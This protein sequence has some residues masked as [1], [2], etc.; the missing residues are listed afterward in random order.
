MRLTEQENA[1]D[2]VPLISTKL[3]MKSFII[4]KMVGSRREKLSGFPAGCKSISKRLENSVSACRGPQIECHRP[5]PLGS[6]LFNTV[7]NG[8][9]VDLR[10]MCIRIF[11]DT[12]GK[13]Y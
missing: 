5:L 12:G 13:G 9:Q 4:Y 11:N 1:I 10:G 6:A 2:I 7:I 8:I 3:L